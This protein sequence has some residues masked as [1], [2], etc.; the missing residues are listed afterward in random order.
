MEI[1]Y[2]IVM[3]KR[4]IYD[5]LLQWKQE[6]HQEC[7]LIKGQRQVGKTYIVN[8]F[9]RTNY[10][11][12][13]YINFLENPE[14]TNIFEGS[15][16]ATDI[17][18]RMSSY[19]HDI[20]FIEENT[21]IFI[22]EIQECPP[23]RTALKFLAL[24]NRYDVIASGSLLGIN[25]KGITSIPVGYERQITM[26]PLDFTEFLWASGRDDSVINMLRDH[27]LSHTPLDTETNNLFLDLFR[28][29]M[30]VGGM[31]EVVNDFFNNHNLI[32][33]H[34]SQQK[35]IESYLSD[36]NRYA[37]NIALKQRVEECFHSVP[38]Q[39]SKPYKRF[40]YRDVTENGRSDKYKRPLSWLTEANIISPC[41]N[42]SLPEIPL[43]GYYIPEE[44]KIYFNDIGLLTSMY[45]FETQSLLYRN[46]LKGPILGGIYENA[47]AD[48]LLSN[49]HPLYYYK[50]KDN[51]QEIEFLIER[52]GN[53]IPI[54]VKPHASKSISLNSFAI[55]Y[56]SK[57]T[58]KLVNGQ[59]NVDNGKLTLPMYMSIFL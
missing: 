15:L 4:K 36:I 7:L 54:D 58:V 34:E 48:V 53:V 25:Y 13:I 8:Y 50:R 27:Y 16:N 29:Y 32:S 5:Y 14:Y 39:I 49:G 26:R 42:L 1:S 31:P 43:N 23:A 46:E 9:G 38:L 35:I 37:D 47:I 59:M 3:L 19:I 57:L 52:D 44:F 51:Q 30:V 11:S 6:K 21:L 41:Y 10:K 2:D 20:K 18:E 33:M 22:D 40:L 12:Y 56:K 24:D 17:Y 28:L 55:D 45:G